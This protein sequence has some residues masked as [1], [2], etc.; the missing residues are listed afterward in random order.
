MRRSIWSSGKSCWRVQTRGA[1]RSFPIRTP[2]LAFPVH[3]LFIARNG[4]Y[5]FEN[6]VTE[7]LARDS[8]YEFAFMFAPLRLKGATGSPGN[9][10]AI[11]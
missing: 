10:L 9:P 11:R 6:L 3:Q 1:S 5:I 7:E 8:A 4:I 2:T